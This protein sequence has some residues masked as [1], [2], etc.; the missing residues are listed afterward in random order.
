[1]GDP[2][3]VN[4]ERGLTT[5]FAGILQRTQWQ[6]Y[7]FVRG[8]AGNDEWARD[9]V[10]DVFV[11]A[12]RLAQRGE[13]PFT[14]DALQLSEEGA[15]RWLFHVAYRQAIS[16]LRRDR[17]IQWHS[18]DASD[19]STMLEPARLYASPPF[20]DRIAEA[21]ALREALGSLSPEDV[22]CVLLNVVQGFTSAEIA[23]IIGS[24][25][26]AAKRRLSRA[27]QRLRDAYFAQN[28]G[29]KER[30]RHE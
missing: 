15:R 13:P 7:G 26:D 17:V 9:V 30:Q 25:A 29:L 28:V 4:I 1:M 18:L 21:E 24:T 11:E 6:L 22:A 16:A 20:E 14:R 27:K 10:Q 3:A 2:S 12:W 8:L 5:A 23:Q 19:M